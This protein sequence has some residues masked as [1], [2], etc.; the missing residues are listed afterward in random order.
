MADTLKVL[1]QSNPSAATLTDLYTAGGAGA[2]VSSLVVCN[3]SATPTSFRVS[4]A[5]AGAADD[6]KQYLYYNQPLEGNDT[7]IATIGVTLAVTDKLRVYASAATVSFSA[8][9]VEV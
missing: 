7:F 5:V 3:R 9:G 6:D 2:T 8:F 4:A 1:G